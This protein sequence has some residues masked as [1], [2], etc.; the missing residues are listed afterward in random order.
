MNA[1][2]R[3][4]MIFYRAAVRAETQKFVT[5]KEYLASQQADG[6]EVR[7][8]EIANK[9]DGSRSTRYRNAKKLMVRRDD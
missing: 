5:A 4:N 6:E 3:V 9:L 2:K 8:S 7:I 1:T